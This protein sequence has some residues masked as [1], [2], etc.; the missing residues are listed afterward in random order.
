MKIFVF[1]N[2]DIDD[3]KRAIEV[4]K[5]FEGFRGIEFLL[6]NLNSDLPMDMEGE[7]IILDVI[8]GIDKVTVFNENDLNKLIL[9]TRN[10]VHD[11]D[12]GFQLKYLQKIG[13]MKKV[14]IIGIPQ[15][16]DIDYDLIHSIFRKLVA[17]DIQGS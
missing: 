9:P 8:T 2:P 11:Y 12:L 14:T 15:F 6:I 3:D 1:G 10:T 16:G 13:K 17:Q 5:K 7:I 4:M